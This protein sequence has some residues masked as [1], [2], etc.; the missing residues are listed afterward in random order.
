[1][2]VCLHLISALITYLSEESDDKTRMGVIGIGALTGYLLGLRG[3]ILR[4]LFY[5]GVV[6]TGMSAICYPNETY[7][8]SQSTI[9][10]S[11]KFVKIAY[12]FI[13]GG[14]FF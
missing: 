2:E 12:N 8:F 13:Y 11:K 1:M 7:A 6:A 9:E 10:E 5:S 14:N 3:G 4:R